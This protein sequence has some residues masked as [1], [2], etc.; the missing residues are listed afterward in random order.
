MGDSTNYRCPNCGAEGMCPFYE[1]RGI[2]VHSCMMVDSAHAA[3][4]FP[5]R[6]LRL[7]FCGQCG[8]VA[9]V[10][11]DSDVQ[12]YTAG[13]EEQ[14]SYSP[15]F[16]R[17]QT[18]L[19]RNL[20]ERYDL[21]GKD[22]VEIGCGKGDFLV[23]LCEAGGNR[24]VGID[25]SCDPQRMSG[26]GGGGVRFIAELYS[27]KHADLPC[28]FLCC[29]HTLEHI[30]NTS[31]F[32]DN[33]REVVGDNDVPV[34]IEVPDVGRVLREQAF[35][36]IYYE[37]CSYF[38]LGSLARV[39]RAN[40]FDV[41]ELAQ[42]FDDQYLLI[43]A[44]PTARSTAASLAQEDDLAQVTREVY[45]FTRKIGE[46]IAGWRACI[47]DLKKSGKRVAIW[48]SGS[49]CV[50]FL[51]TVGVARE[52]DAVIDINPHRHGKYLAGSGKQVVAPETL[53]MTPAEAI[54]VMNP[55]Y[56]D[57]IRQQLDAM[58]VQAEL[59]PA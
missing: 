26:R 44:R 21:R 18:E 23:E 5:T 25:P 1:S 4:E 46:R 56:C 53:R 9:N 15:R 40:R 34:F 49:K 47:A 11:F 10:I 48:G 12:H 41:V 8:F 55:V 3:L 31:E 19:I 29:R 38:S 30:H 28:D 35:W 13:Y 2:P 58:G 27:Q 51:S 20:I 6:D 50:S 59:I 39:F 36:D 24:G 57:E 32:I 37:H 42:D 52:I 45:A 7:G 43:V 22:V 14:Q 16:R 54:L 33:I 17:F